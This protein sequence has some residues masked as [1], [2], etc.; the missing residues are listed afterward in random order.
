MIIRMVFVISASNRHLFFIIIT[1]LFMLNDL[2][3][4]IVTTRFQNSHIT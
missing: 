2:K 3:K 4:Q 1:M